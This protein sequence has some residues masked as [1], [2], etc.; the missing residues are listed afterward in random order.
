[1]SNGCSKQIVITNISRLLI[2][3]QKICQYSHDNNQHDPKIILYIYIYILYIYIYIYIYIYS[4]GY[5]I[6]IILFCTTI[7]HSH[8]ANWQQ[9][10]LKV[11]F[12]QSYKGAAIT[13]GTTTITP[14]V[15]R[16]RFIFNDYFDNYK[17]KRCSDSHR[18]DCGWKGKTYR[19]TKQIRIT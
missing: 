5:F 12:T 16:E 3:D 11:R 9:N 1:M 7:G 19:S 14:Y 17:T 10:K 4:E 2:T 6:I 18:H 13:T 15:R 8:S